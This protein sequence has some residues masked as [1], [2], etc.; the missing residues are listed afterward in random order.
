MLKI[1]AF[2]LIGNPKR[3]TCGHSY[4]F[5][6]FAGFIQDFINQKCPNPFSIFNSVKS[7]HK[8]T[9]EIKHSKLNN[10]DQHIEICQ[11]WIVPI[12]F[13][14]F[15]FYH[16]LLTIFWHLQIYPCFSAC[17]R[18]SIYR[19]VRR[20]LISE[21]PKPLFWFRPDTETETLIGR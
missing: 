6:I 20:A 7:L 8:N 12:Y 18:N 11:P 14:A 3:V 1:S 10:P 9:V 13:D 16:L 21:R 4:P 2:Y 15:E 17:T 19:N 5:V